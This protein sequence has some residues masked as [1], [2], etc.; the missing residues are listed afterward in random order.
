M[1][2][3]QNKIIE[4]MK[5]QEEYKSWGFTYMGYRQISD[6]LKVKQISVS[7]S[8]RTLFTKGILTDCRCK[9]QYSDTKYRLE[10]EERKETI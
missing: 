4:L 5:S 9:D 10:N 2:E 7:N 1:T 6:I 8:M 3:L